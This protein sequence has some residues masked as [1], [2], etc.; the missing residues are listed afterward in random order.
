[1]SRSPW[2]A[3]RTTVSER[4]VIIAAS[5]IV[6][7]R[8][9]DRMSGHLAIRRAALGWGRSG[10][11]HLICT[12]PLEAGCRRPYEA[13]EP[14]ATAALSAWIGFEIGFCLLH[15]FRSQVC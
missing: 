2:R 13:A 4:D 6:C 1:M 11:K 14:T 7:E 15:G 9:P 8:G 5:D 10:S 3:E 12:T